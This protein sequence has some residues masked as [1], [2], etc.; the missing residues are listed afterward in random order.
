MKDYT[1]IDPQ[2]KAVIKIAETTDPAHADN[3][4]AATKQL[5]QNTMKNRADIADAV[6]IAKGRCTGYVFD[7]YDDLTAWVSDPENTK[8]LKLGDNLYIRALNVPDYWWDGNGIQQLET[9]KVDLSELAPISHASAGTTYGTSSANLYGHAKASSTTPKVA[10]TAS[11]GS[12]TDKFARGDHVHPLQTSVSGNAGTATKLQTSRKIN[13]V[14]FDGTKDIN[15]CTILL[16]TLSAGATTL[17]FTSAAITDDSL[18]DV[19]TD[20]YGVNPS[21]ITQSGN[22]LTLTFDAQS[23]AVSV[24]VKVM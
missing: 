13:G 11:A 18:I 24:K 12:E 5:L 15:T 9:Q 14:P 4:N 7:T 19:Y 20:S 6:I 22:T 17:T 23:K 16:K 1:S 2:F 8:D 10:G 3:I 21:N